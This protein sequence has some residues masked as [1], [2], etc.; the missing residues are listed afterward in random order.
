M[1]L[2]LDARL[3]QERLDVSSE[4]VDVSL[5]PILRLPTAVTWNRL[6][7]RPRSGDLTRPMRAEVRDP[8]WMLARQW[9]LGEFDGED[10][11]TPIVARMLTETSAVTHMSLRGEPARALDP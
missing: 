4:L 10:A 3:L 2:N 8:F 7:G 11:G 1:P 9:Q 6:E 5:S